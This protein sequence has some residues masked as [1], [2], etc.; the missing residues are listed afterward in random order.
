MFE[1]LFTEAISARGGF[2]IRLTDSA[3]DTGKIYA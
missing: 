3:E 1:S 2:V